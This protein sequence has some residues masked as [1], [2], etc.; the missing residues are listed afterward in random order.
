MTLKGEREEEWLGP[1]GTPE[2]QRQGE[3]SGSFCPP[4]RHLVI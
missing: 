4:P 3:S 2:W 1:W